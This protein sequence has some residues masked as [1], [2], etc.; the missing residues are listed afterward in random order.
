MP[1][2]IKFEAALTEI[3]QIVQSLELGGPDLNAALA[4][5]GRGIAL[6]AS[7]QGLLD[8]AE[9]SVALLTGVDEAGAPITAPFDASA[10]A[11]TTPAVEPPAIAAATPTLAPTRKP[12]A[13]AAKPV[14]EPATPPIPTTMSSI[15]DTNPYPAGTTPE[16]PF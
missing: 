11:T 14:P 9:R 3:E 5:Y 8:K 2:P 16:A 1:E 15:P 10:T 12:R 6:L 4:G 7:C 13:T